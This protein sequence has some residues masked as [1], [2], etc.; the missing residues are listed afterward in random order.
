MKI[1]IDIDKETLQKA[2]NVLC[3]SGN[4]NVLSLYRKLAG[5]PLIEEHGVFHYMQHTFE[6]DDCRQDGD[7]TD[8]AV[9]FLI[10]DNDQY[11]MKWFSFGADKIIVEGEPVPEGLIKA[12][13]DYFGVYEE[14]SDE[15]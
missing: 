14:D 15:E 5:I 10:G 2:M 6:L 4:K 3:N 9:C 12:I 8:K 7:Y 13:D 1:S 11:L